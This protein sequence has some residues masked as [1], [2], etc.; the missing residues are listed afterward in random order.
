MREKGRRE[1]DKGDIGIGN[2]R[3]GERWKGREREDREGETRRDK[4][5]GSTVYSTNHWQCHS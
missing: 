4:G 3:E 5:S 1:G 2:R